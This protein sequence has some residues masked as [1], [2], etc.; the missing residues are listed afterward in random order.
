MEGV[1]F[2]RTQVVLF[3]LLLQGLLE[4]LLETL[5]VR[6]WL[7]LRGLESELVLV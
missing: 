6:H 7:G 1:G 4:S 5:E 3:L 2:G